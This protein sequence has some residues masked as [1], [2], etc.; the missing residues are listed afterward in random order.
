MLVVAGTLVVATGAGD[1]CPSWPLCTQ[2]APDGMVAWQLVHRGLAGLAGLSLVGFVVH[3]RRVAG[4][5]RGWRVGATVLVGLLVAA[6]AFG[7]GSALSRASAGW[8][9]VHLAVAAALWGTLVTLVA[10]LAS[11]GPVADM[12]AERRAAGV[13]GAGGG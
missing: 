1:D 9:D 4:G 13:V 8:Q 10:M 12:R 11:R 6:A 5:W 3:N 7:A 2:T